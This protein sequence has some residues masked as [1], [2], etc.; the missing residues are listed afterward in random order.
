MTSA[1]GEPAWEDEVCSMAGWRLGWVGCK[2]RGSSLDG[3]RDLPWLLPLLLP[4]LPPLPPPQ[5]L[6]PLP[7]L[8]LSP[9]P[10]PLLPPLQPLLSP[11]LSLSPLP[12]LSVLPPPLPGH[13]HGSFPPPRHQPHECQRRTGAP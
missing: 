8:S 2:Q 12:S 3:Y 6:L 10:L 11:P 13:V 5:P 1:S 9:L 4:P 7:R